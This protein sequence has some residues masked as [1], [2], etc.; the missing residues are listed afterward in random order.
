MHE[1]KFIQPELLKHE[2]NRGNFLMLGHRVSFVG[3]KTERVINIQP[4]GLE[5]LIAIRQQGFFQNDGVRV[6]M[7]QPSLSWE[8]GAA[9]TFLEI[10]AMVNAMSL[11]Q[12]FIV[13]IEN[14][15]GDPSGFVNDLGSQ[16]QE[17]GE[18]FDVLT[19]EE[20]D[21]Y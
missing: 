7:R 2:E 1:I 12:M 11:A 18:Q 14:F 4:Q 5:T 19:R 8:E 9:R 20:P 17:A 3:A 21:E 13:G 6:V 15:F 16:L 10:D